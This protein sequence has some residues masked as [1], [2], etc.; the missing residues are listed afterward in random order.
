MISKLRRSLRW[1]RDGGIN[2]QENGKEWH[3]QNRTPRVNCKDANVSIFVDPDSMRNELAIRNTVYRPQNGDKLNKYIAQPQFTSKHRGCLRHH[4]RSAPTLFMTLTASS[5]IATLV[6]TITPGGPNSILVYQDFAASPSPLVS[7]PKQFLL[8]AYVGGNGASGAVYVFDLDQ[9]LKQG[10]GTV[11]LPATPVEVLQFPGYVPIG[12]A[13]QPGTGDLY[14]A[15][16]A[17]DGSNPTINV[18]AKTQGGAWS[19]SGNN[20]LFDFNALGGFSTVPANFAFDAHGFLW[21]TSFGAA[22]GTAF[23]YL[24]CFRN[25]P[26]ATPKSTPEFWFDNHLDAGG[27]AVQLSV[28]PLLGGVSAPAKLQGLSSAEGIAFDPAGN[29]WVA[30][31]NEE[32]DGSDVNPKFGGIGGGSLLMIRAEYLLNLLFSGS[33]SGE[34]LLSAI[35][36]ASVTVYYIND[37]AQP[38]GLFFDGFTLYINDENNFGGDGNPILWSM[39]VKA[40]STPATTLS[41]V[42]APVH[43][44]NP[45]NGSMAVFNYPPFSQTPALAQLLI[46]D[47]AT[48]DFRVRRRDRARQYSGTERILGEPGHRHRRFPCFRSGGPRVHHRAW[49]PFQSTSP[50]PCSG[51]AD[52]VRRRA[53]DALQSRIAALYLAQR[54]GR[55]YTA[56]GWRPQP[57]PEG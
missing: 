33:P 28:T 31:N 27:A 42:P 51:V 45:G 32:F 7:S 1:L 54:S 35:P 19:T 16:P 48:S 57:T 30:N 2:R 5:A 18:F 6:G 26:N 34:I 52:S 17:V 9:L 40:D 14:V 21:M 8:I 25:I 43:T 11:Q 13:I 10:P 50:L 12:M 37:N 20:T 55:L 29:L 24:T 53:V 38:G 3:S 36:A 22:N 15:T 41:P 23:N 56:P 44:T 46:R 49:T 39:Q 4:A 47:W